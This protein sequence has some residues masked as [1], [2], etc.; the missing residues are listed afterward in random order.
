MVTELNNSRK[1]IR[2]VDFGSPLVDVLVALVLNA[3]DRFLGT[4]GHTGFKAAA[5]VSNP[6]HS[7]RMHTRLTFLSIAKNK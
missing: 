7:Y 3:D 5:G 4:F 1:I 2:T 6:E